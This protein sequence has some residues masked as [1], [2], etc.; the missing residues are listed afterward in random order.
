MRHLF[1][2]L[3]LASSLLLA[4]CQSGEGINE[5]NERAATVERQNDPNDSGGDLTTPS[6]NSPAATTT[7]ATPGST[8]DGAAAGSPSPSAAGGRPPGNTNNT[9]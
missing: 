1:L 6:A 5:Q 9:R 8:L 3:G 2:T 7:G 4:G